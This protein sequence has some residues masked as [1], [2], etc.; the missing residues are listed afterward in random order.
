MPGETATSQGL[1]LEGAPPGDPAAPMPAKEEARP[2]PEGASYDAAERSPPSKGCPPPPPPSLLPSDPLDTRIVMGEETHC[3][4][5]LP[6][7]TP[8]RHPELPP[9]RLD[10]DLFFTAPSTPV[11]TGGP[12][13]K[14]EEDGGDAE[15]EGLGSPPTSPSG[16]YMTAEG[17]SWGSSGTASTSPSCSPNLLAE[18]PDGEPGPAAFIRRSSSSSSSSEDVAVT[19]IG[20]EE[21]DEEEDDDDDEGSGQEEG[22]RLPHSHMAAPG[23]IPAALLPFRGSLLFEAEAVEITLVPAQAAAEPLSGEDEEDEDEEEDASTSASFLRS[24]SE[25]SINEGVDESFAFH[26]DTSASSDSA[27]YDGEEDERLYGTERHALGGPQM[28]AATPGDTEPSSEAS[29]DIELHLRGDTAQLDGTG[30]SAG[31]SAQHEGALSPSLL[32]PTDGSEEDVGMGQRAAPEEEEVAMAALAVE[33][34][35]ELTGQ[36]PIEPLSPEVNVEP[37]DEASVKALAAQVSVEPGV[38]A[39]IEALGAKPV[40]EASVELMDEAPMEA[41]DVEGDAGE[42]CAEALPAEAD[43]ERV[44][45]A[46]CAEVNVG[47]MDEALSSS[48]SEMEE[49]PSLEPDTTQE[50]DPIPEECPAPQPPVPTEPALLEEEILLEEEVPSAAVMEAQLE[51]EA[52]T[53][54][55]PCAG[56]TKD[57]QPNGLGWDTP[58]L[59]AANGDRELDAVP[60]ESPEPLCPPEQGDD[61]GEPQE[62]VSGHGDGRTDV[63]PAPL[64]TPALGGDVQGDVI[65]QPL[66]DTS[67]CED[68]VASGSESPR[69]ALSDGGSEVTQGAEEPLSPALG[70]MD[71]PRAASEDEASS[72]DVERGQSPERIP[73]EWDATA[74]SEDSS[75]ELLDALCSHTDPSFFNPPQDSAGEVAAPGV[76]S[77]APQPC[78][79]LCVLP[80]APAPPPLHFT[81]S[82]QEVYVGIPPDPLELLPPPGALLE[83]A[84]DRRQVASMLQGVFGDLPAPGSPS[85]APVELPC[86]PCAEDEA[87]APEPKETPEPSDAGSIQCSPPASLQLDPAPMQGQEPPSKESLLLLSVDPN[88]KV[89]VEGE[90]S[91]PPPEEVEKEGVKA[92]SSPVKEEEEVVVVAGSIPQEEEVIMV[93]GS[94]LQEEEEEVVVTAAGFSPMEEEEGEAMVAGSIPQEEVEEEVM[95]AGSSPKRE[96]EEVVMVA[97]SSPKKEEEEEVMEAGSSPKE[98]EA[99]MVAGS[100]PQE[101][102]EAVVI[103]AGSSSTPSL[104]D[105][106]TEATPSLSAAVLPL[107]PP[108]EPS[109]PEDPVP[110]EPT[111]AAVPTPELAVPAE[112]AEPVPKVVAPVAIP[113]PAPCPQLSKLIQVPPLSSSPLPRLEDTS[114]LS[115]ATRPEERLSVLP[116]S[117]KLLEAPEPS[118]QKEKPRGRKAPAGSKGARGLE[119]EGGPRRAPRG[120]VQSESSSSSEAE[121]PYRVPS[122]AEHLPAIALLEDKA[123]PRHGEANHKGSC[124]ESE[125]NDES[126]PELEE[127]EGAEPRPM[128]TQAPLTHSL[129]TGEESISKAK[130][131]RSEKKA[132][133][134]MSKLGLRQI[135]GVTRITI[136][137]SKNIL[138]VITKPDVFKSPA[139]DIYIVFGEAKIE[140]LSQQVHKAAAEKFKV[141]MEHSPLITETAPALTIKEESEEEEEVDETGLEVRDIELVMAQA[142]VS[143]PKAVRALRHNNNDIVN[144]IM[145]L[146]M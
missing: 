85:Q 113:L 15:S 114:G 56:E 132:R 22:F 75:P 74:A 82:E 11:R 100:I 4:P 134:A 94:I 32:E 76:P 142:N 136:R 65:E 57:P 13:L 99:V 97:G 146:T 44:D 140:D 17:G 72:K 50:L 107:E 45:E 10:P 117:R 80:P 47:R 120:S 141:P 125:S 19:S 139:S 61:S 9:A 67:P 78:L 92:G 127:P 38:E 116:A 36:A 88:A 39:S 131:S 115:E 40:A 3:P 24:L 1:Q 143:R 42:T 2:Q 133:K 21:E 144:A 79:A 53:L 20:Q 34:D 112:A 28:A 30:V 110:Q 59:P 51:A 23:L 108:P 69:V 118:P 12:R 130:Q 5:E 68:G 96:E 29:G 73:G 35:T 66:E 93:A 106:G 129:G 25:T 103:V 58:S 86:P 124:N 95:V 55:P 71:E 14:P 135:H 101:E 105:E 46:L 52:G 33:A 60:A 91:L 145:E 63:V 7:K 119:A 16:S 54:Q 81:A 109:S 43:V 98:E 89:T 137:K 26:D 123:A 62:D 48:S 84:E 49:A 126:I 70:G 64:G 27:S 31:G 104:E 77:P 90:H 37:S 6:P 18:V 87:A 128:Q 8:P 121:L 102:E 41:L 138:F 111:E 122:P 83:S